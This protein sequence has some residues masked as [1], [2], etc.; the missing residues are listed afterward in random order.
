MGR[1]AEKISLPKRKLSGLPYFAREWSSI[2]HGCLHG[3]CGNGSSLLEDRNRKSS[4]WHHYSLVAGKVIVSKVDCIS[5]SERIPW[6][7]LR[8]RA[9]IA[10]TVLNGVTHCSKKFSDAETK[11]DVWRQP[12]D[13]ALAFP[14]TIF[15]QANERLSCGLKLSRRTL[16]S[17]T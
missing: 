6:S 14:A 13:F 1:Y 5:K 12:W 8:V 9:A 4:R 7:C 2:K 16:L 11:Y 10:Q 3:K 15:Q 17:K